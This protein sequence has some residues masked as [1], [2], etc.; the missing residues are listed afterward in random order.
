LRSIDRFFDKGEIDGCEIKHKITVYYTYSE[1]KFRVLYDQLRN[2]EFT[3]Y[4]F[5]LESKTDTVN[6]VKGLIS[7]NKLE[8]HIN[9][10]QFLVDDMLFFAPVDIPR[11]L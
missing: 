3:Q 10:F 9:F 5:V 6:E 1:D 8:G 2:V 4:D 7:N 11:I